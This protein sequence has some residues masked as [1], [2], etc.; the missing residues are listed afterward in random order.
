[1]NA[2]VYQIYPRSFADS[3]SDGYGDIEGI[4]SK[5]D[6]LA[7]LGV[8][9]IWLSPIHQSPQDDNGYD[10]SD[11]QAI[12]PMFG[13][14]EQFDRLVAGLHARGMKLVMDLVVNHTSDEHPWFQASRDPLNPK[15]DWYWWREGNG[16]A[17]PNNWASF[18]LGSAWEFDDVSQAYYLHLFTRKQPDLNWENPQVR[19]AV[20]AMMTWWLDR[21]VDGFRLDVINF[22]SKVPGLPDGEVAPGELHGD[23]SPY[24][25]NGPRLHEFLQEMNREVFAPRDADF[26]TV[27]ETPGISVEQ[28]RL[29]TDLA[30]RELD[31]VF[32]FEHLEL[33]HGTTKWDRRPLELPALKKNL[34]KWQEGLADAGWNSL[35]WDNHDHPRAVSR[36]GDP[37]YWYESATLLATI[38]HLHKGTPYIYQGEELGMTDYPFTSIDE[39]QDVEA[40]N[41]YR[42]EVQKKGKDPHAVV[43]SM[44]PVARDNARTPMQWTASPQAGFTDGQPWFPVNP[45]HTIINAAAQV[46]DEGSIYSFYKRL[47]ALRHQDPVVQQGTFELLLADDP[48][49]YVFTRTL[50]LEQ[51]LVVGNCSAGTV[52]LPIDAEGEVVVANYPAADSGE[53]R[54]W[55]VRVVRR[56]VGP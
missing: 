38:L 15:R 48:V 12:D 8:D 17:P 46:D 36:F 41:Y 40:I 33:D 30:R 35:Y 28:A 2:V 42:E 34:A 37:E 29:I 56:K 1:M 20:Y 47:I 18:F 51:L 16:S 43:E 3:N 25:A 19:Q 5:L 21:G 7:D 55:E 32:Q 11:Y 14:L 13:T 49:L 27:G 4:I 22:I 45:N 23:G 44:K 54:A 52:H 10:I 24:Y 6:Y 53:L 39:F 50:G 26:L 31:M 9:V